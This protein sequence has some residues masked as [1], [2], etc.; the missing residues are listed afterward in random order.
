MATCSLWNK[1]L[2]PCVQTHDSWNIGWATFSSGD[3]SFAQI[4]S[5]GS[6]GKCE[7]RG[8]LEKGHDAGHGAPT[9]DP[10]SI[11]TNF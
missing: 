11:R 3:E 6:K 10:A 8:G 7:G 1:L 2:S 9:Q 5:S 4:T